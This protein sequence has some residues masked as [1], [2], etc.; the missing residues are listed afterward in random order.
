MHDNPAL[1][2]AAAECTA[3]YPVFVI[4]DWF[5][6]PAK[7]CANRYRFLLE[8]LT[9]LDASLRKVNSRLLVL[10]GKPGEV[11]PAVLKAC[12][13]QALYF[14]RDT[15]PYA[16]ARDKAVMA[17]AA[18]SGVEVVV[19]HGHT[20]Y[21]P[22]VI[23][24]KAKGSV[25]TTYQGFV[26]LVSALPPPAKPLAAPSVASMPPLGPLESL[27]PG[28]RGPTKA[29]ASSSVSS[30]AGVGAGAG[31]AAAAAHGGADAGSS[32]SSSSSPPAFAVP[33]LAEMGYDPAAAMTPFRGGETEALR[34]LEANMARKEWVAAFQKPETSPNALSPSTTVLSPYLKF[35]ALSCR[36]FYWRL[37]EIYAASKAHSAP[38]VSLEGQL[39]WREFFYANAFAYPNYDRMVGNPVCKQ[40][41]WEFDPAKIKAWEEGRTGYPWID[42]AMAQ[43]RAEGWLHHLARHAVACFLT[44]GDLY[45]SWEHG[46]KVF[47]KLLLDSDWAINNGESRDD[48][49]S[50][51][52]DCKGFWCAH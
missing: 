8:C 39:L 6:D 13:A 12:S 40:I 18:S 17:A 50:S 49:M 48:M 46:A 34:R 51:L 22:D 5:A 42:A 7:I 36:T 1:A 45:Q 26:K 38:P 43:L 29:A 30:S 47:D 27:E 24:A 35:G 41:A 31:S 15:E 25:P 20:L 44:R 32:G 11:L 37:K 9:D 2:R 16:V 3:L 21:D 52:T 4:D 10:R 28:G 19:A 33:S 23:V 14:E